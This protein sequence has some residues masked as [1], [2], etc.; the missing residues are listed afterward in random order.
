[1]R[2]IRMAS[3]E[4]ERCKDQPT[5]S[6]RFSPECPVEV[7]KN[8]KKPHK[9]LP[10]VR[11]VPLAPLHCRLAHKLRL[12][13][14]E[15]NSANPRENTFLKTA[16]RRVTEQGLSANEAQQIINTYADTRSTLHRQ[17][18]QIRCNRKIFLICT[19]RS[20][21]S[22][23][24]RSRLLPLLRNYNAS[25]VHIMHNFFSNAII[26]AIISLQT[27]LD[28]SD[29]EGSI[30]RDAYACKAQS[31]EMVDYETGAVNFKCEP[32]ELETVLK[33]VTDKGYTVLHTDYSFKA[34]RYIKLNE[35]ERE[36][37]K[38]FRAKLSKINDFDM[39]FDNVA[40][41]KNVDEV[42]SDVISADALVE[43][44]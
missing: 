25:Y 7:P 16:I 40:G 9:F 35:R 4:S 26:E 13:I 41:E 33:A 15:G 36:E 29:L 12:A 30:A 34:K 27:S 42:E 39:F 44:V 2:S 17:L 24:L 32:S 38:K 1:M 18:L 22:G 6:R 3:K 37:Y 19:L 28:F 14:Y 10:L 8:T 11:S 43:T 21:I 31:I 5:T 23:E 20:V